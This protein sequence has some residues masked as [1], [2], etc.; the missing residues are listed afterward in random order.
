[1]AHHR[2]KTLGPTL[3]RLV[4]WFGLMMLSIFWFYNLVVGMIVKV[5]YPNASLL[6]HH[7]S[8]PIACLLVGFWLINSLAKAIAYGYSGQTIAR[9]HGAHKIESIDC[10]PEEALALRINQKIAQQ[11]GVAPTQLYVFYDE[12]G[13]NALNVGYRQ[14]DVVIILTWGALQSLTRDELKGILAH[15]YCHIVHHSYMFKSLLDIGLSGFLL[16]DNLG[17]RLIIQATRPHITVMQ[18][19][20]A[21]LMIVVGMLLCSCGSIGVW[22]GRFLKWRIFAKREWAVDLE[23]HELSRHSGLVSAL[24][25]V[26]VHRYGARLY[27]AQAE[28]LSQ[29]CFANPVGHQLWLHLW[30]A[31]PQRINDLEFQLYLPDRADKFNFQQKVKN[32]LTALLLPTNEQQIL[33]HLAQE[34]VQGLHQPAILHHLATSPNAE[35]QMRALSPDI[36]HSMARQALILRAMDTATGCREIIVAIFLLRQAAYGRQTDTQVSH[37]IFDSLNQLDKRVWGYIFRQALQK[38]QPMPSIMAHPYVLHLTSIAQIDGQISLVDALMVECVKASQQMMGTGIPSHLNQ[39]HRA[40]SHI[41]D[42]ILAIPTSH[43]DFAQK[44]QIRQQIL[45]Q[46]I[47]DVPPF[48]PLEKIDFAYDLTVLT[49]LLERERL[50]VLHTLE[51][52]LWVDYPITQEQLD[53]IALL[54]WRFGF[55]SHEAEQRLIQH[56]RS[57]IV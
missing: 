34:A 3:M 19:L 28:S 31:L 43:L 21:S 32:I 46:L 48:N 49:G 5:Y 16:L 18:R 2:L 39:A 52:L 7:Y 44:T 27:R 15:Q 14:H 6:W 4:V 20:S 55:D 22:F 40:L 50:Y 29:Y 54:Y 41:V 36:R 56:S 17:K 33:S 24:K 25:R 57:L 30:Q 10:V 8:L 11:C 1:M 51:N 13:I 47:N 12:L 38:I 26:Q 37:A 45:H 23:A 42:G 35:D 9:Y 53:C